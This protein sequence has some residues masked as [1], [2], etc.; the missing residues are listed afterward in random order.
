MTADRAAGQEDRESQGAP[1]PPRPQSVP[2]FKGFLSEEMTR[3]MVSIS[4]ALCSPGAVEGLR[5]ESGWHHG[6]AKGIPTWRILS[7]SPC[8]AEL[9]P[10]PPTTQ[11]ARPAPAFPRT[12]SCLPVQRHLMAEGSDLCPS[13]TS[14]RVPAL[15]P[16]LVVLSGIGVFADMR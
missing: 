8:R 10:G 11:L 9:P 15:A 16:V 1:L 5:E 2:S 7:P 4:G 13:Q 14:V 6:L 3:G 12:V